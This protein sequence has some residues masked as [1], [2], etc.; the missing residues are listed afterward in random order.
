MP[1]KPEIICAA[2]DLSGSHSAG[3]PGGWHGPKI[4]TRPGCGHPEAG[5]RGY[6]GRLQRGT[7]GCEVEQPP[8]RGEAGPSTAAPHGGSGV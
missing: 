2:I 8:V 7:L 4:A 6:R 3:H 1:R 5:R